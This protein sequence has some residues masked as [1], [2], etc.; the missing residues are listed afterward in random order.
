VSRAATI[1]F[2]IATAGAGYWLGTNPTA[3]P[4]TIEAAR[5][6]FEKPKMIS[7]M[8]PQSKPSGVI[9]YYRDPDGKPDYS[10][11]P[12][13][14]ADGRAFEAVDASKDVRFDGSGTMKDADDEPAPS[15]DQ[16]RKIK[17]YRNPMGLPDVSP[18][19]K[20]DNMG[21]DYIPVY[22]GGASADAK[23]QKIKFYRNPMG[24][25]DTSPVPKKDNMGMD[26]LPV[27]EGGDADDGKTITVSPGKLQSTGVRSV[28][29]EMKRIVQSVRVP[30]SV[31]LDERRIAIVATR[32]D[33]Y[34]DKVANVTTGDRVKKGEPLLT[35][36]S[37]EINAAA[38]QMISNPGFEGSRRRLENLNVPPD[39]IADMER[40]HKVP[41]TIVWSSPRDGI[42]LE[43][44]AVDGMK[45]A[46][47]AT[48]F[49]IGDISTMWVLADV[50]EHD[51][52]AVRIG[53][54]V[55]VKVRSQPNRTYT[56]HV[57]LI[58]PE[59][60]NAT[61]STRVRVQLPNPDGSLL[62]DMY[63][64]VAI[65]T[66]TPEPVVAVPDDAVIDTGTKQTVIIDRG[67]GR[68][69][70]RP[71]TVGVRGDGFTEIRDGVKAGEKVVTSANFLIDAESNLKA[72]LE[73][74]SAASAGVSEENT[75]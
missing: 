67:K 28:S 10:A 54:S 2:G 72:A 71:V 33:A 9:A 22:A 29:A 65:A 24:L 70:P 69:E 5:A 63:A 37:P 68:L 11:T 51:I 53:Q 46:A 34:I 44:G 73:G 1:A 57:D 59:V 8:R 4:S 25:P 21:M 14:T 23:P 50:P 27:F 74:L 62:A 35:L 3:L 61:R 36:Y 42:V 17:Y 45:A 47:G 66:G 52:G 40:S 38:A 60:N 13:K 12:T 75:P 48:L 18:V 16:P 32:S 41:T 55:A 64:E 20:K 30:G 7:A 39:A 43:R 15:D 26:Y 56:G 58:Y 31:Q 49:K 19:P 6:M